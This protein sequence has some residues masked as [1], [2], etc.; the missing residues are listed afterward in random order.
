MIKEFR[1]KGVSAEGKLIH[2]TFIAANK[3]EAKLNIKDISKKHGINIL[4][5]EEKRDFVYIIK[6]PNKQTIK[7]K[8]SNIPQATGAQKPVILGKICI[9]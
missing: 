9:V 2:G 8:Q 6:L 7:G 1:F 3:K 5:F 4:D